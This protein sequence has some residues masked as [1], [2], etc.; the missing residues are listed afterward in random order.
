MTVPEASDGPAGGRPTY[1]SLLDDPY[2]H[3]ARLRE[4]APLHWSPGRAAWLV[5][6]YDDIV[7]VERAGARDGSLSFG[8]RCAA[9]FAAMPTRV[10]DRTPTLCKAVPRHLG[11]LDG[12]EHG[13]PR[14]LAEAAFSRAVV[15]RLSPSVGAELDA[16]V[17]AV[18]DRDEIELIG[19]LIA[20]MPMAVIVAG[21][22]L[23]S[24]SARDLERW[25][26]ALLGDIALDRMP[27]EA[28]DAKEAAQVALDGLLRVVLRSGRR[29][30]MADALVGAA[31][32]HDAG[33]EDVVRVAA[34]IVIGSHKSLRHAI[35]VALH[36][37]VRHPRRVVEALAAAMLDPL[38][39]ELLRLDPAAQRLTRTA[40]RDIVLETGVVP[41]G[42]RILLLL[43][44]GN[45]DPER[46]P[47]PDRLSL[48]RAP[49]PHLAFGLG[50]H[51]CPGARL[52]RHVT[53]RVL[54]R[55]LGRSRPFALRARD[56][57][58]LRSESTR[59]IAAWPV[60][61]RRRPAS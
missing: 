16:A 53:G 43:G 26:D 12:P 50:S 20:P 57:R 49:C 59:G 38:V 34:Q 5:S 51:Y 31:E 2:P 6:R 61:R 13:L 29:S 18:K 42:D 54:E 19:E 17:A 8:E 40:R 55:L 60:R 3:Y 1:E 39:D 58:W 15:D 47:D 14:K 24:S 4:I 56:A 52:A 46:F 48:E 41:A 11:H 23:P 44:S 36:A 7:A 27:D 28:L 35:S 25:S 30:P 10:R 21:F 37:A 45:R 33:E 9:H 22:G 32:R